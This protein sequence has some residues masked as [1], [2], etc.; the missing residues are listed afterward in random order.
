MARR[1]ACAC[2]RPAVYYDA[3]RGYLQRLCYP[4]WRQRW[5]DELEAL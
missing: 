5:A 3:T 2:G 4:C 1:Y